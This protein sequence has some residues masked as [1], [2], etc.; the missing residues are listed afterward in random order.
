MGSLLTD[1]HSTCIAAPDVKGLE[2]ITMSYQ[3]GLEVKMCNIHDQVSDALKCF[4]IRNRRLF[5]RNLS[6]HQTDDFPLNPDR[7]HV[8]SKAFTGRMYRLLLKGTEAQNS[9]RTHDPPASAI[10]AASLGCEQNLVSELDSPEREKTA[11]A[12]EGGQRPS[13]TA[14]IS[15]NEEASMTG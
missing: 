13:E 12:A 1:S 11:A 3:V 7:E 6:K 8:Y 15:G 10:H 5:E 4:L 9:P 2:P 14:H